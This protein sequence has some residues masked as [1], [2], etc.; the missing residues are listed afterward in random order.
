[1]TYVAFFL[2]SLFLII[3]T[4]LTCNVPVS[5]LGRCNQSEVD[6]LCEGNPVRNLVEQ[7]ESPMGTLVE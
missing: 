2:S 3:W 4:P 6:F 7:L 1:M 5:P